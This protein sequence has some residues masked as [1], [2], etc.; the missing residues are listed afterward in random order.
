[1][2][3]GRDSRPRYV[4]RPFPMSCDNQSSHHRQPASLIASGGLWA[5]ISTTTVRLLTFLQSVIVARLLFPE[6]FG[7]MGIASVTIGTLHVFSQFGIDTFLIQRP[8]LDERIA[9][10]AWVFGILRG[11]LL[12]FVLIGLAPAAG[13]FF[14]EDRATLLIQVLAFTGLIEGFANSYVVS[15][16]RDM[17]FRLQTAYTLT[18]QITAIAVTVGATWVL[19]DVWGLVIGRLTASCIRTIGSFFF[20]TRRPRFEWEAPSIKEFVHFGRHILGASALSFVHTQVDDA[21]VGRTLGK[22]SLGI[23]TL[24]YSISNFIGTTISRILSQFLLPVYATFR[25]RPEERKEA[26][27][28]S[29]GVSALAVFPLTGATILFAEPAILFVYGAKWARMVPAV[30]ILCIFGMMRALTAPMG[31]LLLSLG[32]PDRIT[33]TIGVQVAIV[34]ATLYPLGTRYGIEGVATSV[35]VANGVG[36]AMLLWDIGRLTDI[37][38]RIWVNALWPPAVATL[39]SVASIESS[40][41]LLPTAPVPSIALSAAIGVAVYLTFIF[42]IPESSARAKNL[43]GQLKSIW[44]R[45]P[46]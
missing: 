7:L 21:F 12:T 35:T 18:V 4:V 1:M 25:D 44:H 26:F 33:R 13:W 24:A 36:M 2:E 6:D 42:V 17:K 16:R 37:P 11:L 40:R 45:D 20:V 5:T 29:L 9:N 38:R 28:L 31:S 10:A 41:S 30:Q 27:G 19:R 23:Y 22:A 8:S 39:L 3:C 32:R 15:L 46:S 34:L 14:R 43:F